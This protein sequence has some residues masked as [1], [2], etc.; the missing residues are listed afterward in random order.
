MK[1]SLYHSIAL[2]ALI[3]ALA[4]F[5]APARSQ[6]ATADNAPATPIIENIN[7]LELVPK[8]RMENGQRA[9][10]EPRA[11]RFVATLAQMPTPQKA[12]YLYK[13]MGMMGV[14]NP[15]AVS[16]RVALEY[17]GDKPLAAYVEDQA[18]LRVSKEAKAGERYAFDAIYI[19]NNRYGPALVITAFSKA[20]DK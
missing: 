20:G 17:G 3:L 12:D 7:L 11:V 4:L 15:P 1:Y 6:T 16:K 19:Y 8:T 5:A 13:V 2:A 14:S 10:F 18:A 9:I